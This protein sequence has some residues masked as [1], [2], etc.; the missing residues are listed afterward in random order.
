MANAE[1]T[2]YGGK[3][4]TPYEAKQRMRQMETNMRAQREGIRLLK[5]GEADPEDILALQARYRAQ[6]NEYVKFSNAMGLKQQ[7]ERI[8]VDGLGNQSTVLSSDKLNRKIILMK[9]YRSAVEKGDISS[10]ITFDI[11]DDVAKKIE[12]KLVGLE[13]KDGI[14]IKGYKT[15]F[16]DRQIGQYESSNEPIKGLRQGVPIDVIKECL[17]HPKDIRKKS[18]TDWNYINEDCKVTVNPKTGML[19]QTNPLK[20]K[21]GKK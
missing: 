9:G 15:H 2:E 13:T 11:Y 7:K 21:K 12:K 3:E 14:I 5:E 16:V 20:R 18:E 19:I 4:Y 1:P 10:F 17:Q 8:Y 6:M